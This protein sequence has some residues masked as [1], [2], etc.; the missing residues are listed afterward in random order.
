MKEIKRININLVR[1]KKNSYRYLDQ[2]EIEKLARLIKKNGLL[3]PIIVRK[4][5]DGF[6]IAQGVK[7]YK[8]CLLN[9]M[10][11]ID[12]IIMGS[13][14]D[15]D[16]FDLM[17]SSDYSHLS[18]IE[19]ALIFKRIMAKE[20]ITQHELAKRLNC[21]QSTIANKLRLLKLPEYIKE[22][23]AK[24]I[25]SERHARALLK[26]KEEDL[27]T[28][29]QHIVNKKYTVKNTEQYIDRFYNKDKRPKAYVGNLY[30]GVNTIKE[31]YKRCQEVGLDCHIN[32]VEYKNEVKLIIRFKK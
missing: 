32:E 29:Y 24:N 15:I 13:D 31:A 9:N 27:Q 3:Q 21:T 10:T 19:E 2:K 7:R 12:A 28:I 18:A 6:E 4:K 8:A 23:L 25:I 16:D 14:A 5:N 22:D 11:E 30:I 17:E 1:P 20:K 26:V